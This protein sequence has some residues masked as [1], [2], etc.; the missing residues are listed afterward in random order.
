MRKRQ[1]QDEFYQPMPEEAT[2]AETS[3]M[4]VEGKTP[5]E[6]I[7]KTSKEF[8]GKSG[9]PEQEE[10]NLHRMIKKLILMPLAST[11]AAVT[12]VFASFGTD[13]CGIW[14]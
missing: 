9:G 4:P 7:V 8:E 2:G 3:G 12:I 13:P 1:N 10:N 14:M 11:V 6:P 5:A